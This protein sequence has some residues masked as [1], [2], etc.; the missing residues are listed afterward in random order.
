MQKMI[1]RK[2]SQITPGDSGSK[3]GARIGT[4]ADS[5]IYVLNYSHLRYMVSREEFKFEQASAFV[6]CW[7]I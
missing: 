1:C 7:F 2:Y 6:I 3:V 4:S 5:L